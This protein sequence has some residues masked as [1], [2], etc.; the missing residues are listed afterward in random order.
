VLRPTAA[1]RLKRILRRSRK[2][3]FRSHLH[4]LGGIIAWAMF[5]NDDCDRLADRRTASTASTGCGAMKG[6]PVDF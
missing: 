5:R 1:P 4:P 3:A 6:E 2:E